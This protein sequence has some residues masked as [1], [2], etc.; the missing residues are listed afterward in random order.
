MHTLSHTHA[1]PH[2]HSLGMVSG[3]GEVLEIFISRWP[4]SG[5]ISNW[6]EILVVVGYKVLQKKQKNKT[7]WKVKRENLEEPCFP[8]HPHLKERFPLPKLTGLPR[9][10][11]STGHISSCTMLI[12]HIFP[13]HLKESKAYSSGRTISCLHLSNKVERWYRE[14]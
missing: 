4:Q 1:C 5:F 10:K 14:N 8:S 13:K 2:T 6:A 3:G 11:L 7:S 12:T 9:N